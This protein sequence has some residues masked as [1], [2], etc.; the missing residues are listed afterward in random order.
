MRQRGFTSVRDLSTE[1][2]IL[3]ALPPFAALIGTL[4][5]YIRPRASRAPAGRAPDDGDALSAL[6]RCVRMGIL[7]ESQAS[8]AGVAAGVLLPTS[9]GSL[10]RA[11]WYRS[12]D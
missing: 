2:A 6:E 3:A 7:T 10:S 12:T 9:F 11:P 5:L 4:A 8:N 1:P